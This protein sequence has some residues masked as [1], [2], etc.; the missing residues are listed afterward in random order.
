MRKAVTNRRRIGRRRLGVAL[1]KMAVVLGLS[2]AGPA[3]ATEPAASPRPSV[4]ATATAP[5]PSPASTT[6]LGAAMMARHQHDSDAPPSAFNPKANKVRWDERWT[7][8][9]DWEFVATGVLGVTVFAALMIP[10]EKD[11]WRSMGEFDATAR[12]ALRIS[13]DRTRFFAKDMSDVILGLMIN[14]LVVDATLVAWWGHDRPS[15]AYQMVMMD[16]EALAFTGAVQAVVSGV[17]SRWRPYREKCVGPVETQSQD[18]QDNKQYRSFFSGHT[19]GA[20]T[21]A[22]LMCMHHAY[23]PLYGGGNREILTCAAS[24][25]AAASVGMLRVVSDQHFLSDALVG[26]AF[27]TLSGLGLPWLLHYRTSAPEPGA[28]ASR[29]GSSVSLRLL[30]TPMGLTATGEF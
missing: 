18:C 12:S 20:F 17:T 22:G 26:A 10:P 8:F 23:L 27:G 6:P 5:A 24:F 14:Q 25:A 21:A 3:G 4:T 16:L 13:D 19:S 28:A 15:V 2:A 9:H 11:R 7:K 1:A 30:P 29:Q